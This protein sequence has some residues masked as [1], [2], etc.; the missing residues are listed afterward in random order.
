MRPGAVTEQVRVEA[1]RRALTTWCSTRTFYSDR[2]VFQCWHA[3]DGEG[4]GWHFFRIT[5][6]DAL[7]KE[8]KV[9]PEQLESASADDLLA[10]VWP[11]LKPFEES[12]QRRR[13]VAG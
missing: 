12:E 6:G 9:S 13:D 3:E 4:R 10:S 2:D 5:A 1:I 8:F 11:I 7:L